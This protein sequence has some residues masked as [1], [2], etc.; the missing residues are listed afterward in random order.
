MIYNL[1]TSAM[2]W[3]HQK[4][5]LDFKTQFLAQGG[6]DEDFPEFLKE[7]GVE[8]RGPFMI[9]SDGFD[10]IAALKYRK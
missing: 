8:V 2:A 9:T 1:M 7:Q 10:T 6:R 5:I 3:D 4:M